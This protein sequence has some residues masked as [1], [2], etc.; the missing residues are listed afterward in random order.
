MART[1]QPNSAGSQFYICLNPDSKGY[2]HLE[3]E[4]A[5]FGR[6]IEG[7][8]VVDQL[9][10]GDRMNKI[11]LNDYHPPTEESEK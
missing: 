11:T 10:E 7:L 5:A 4:Y 1:Q 2:Q 6:V 3:G 8:E 9:R